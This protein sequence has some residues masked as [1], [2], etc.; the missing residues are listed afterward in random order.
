M[1][2][3]VEVKSRVISSGGI[4]DSDWLED[5]FI[6]QVFSNNS[7]GTLPAAVLNKNRVLGLYY[8]GTSGD[9]DVD[10]ENGGTIDGNNNLI[11]NT[12]TR[13]AAVLSID[14]SGISQSEPWAWKTIWKQ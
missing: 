14:Q 11:L 3:R 2:S 7:N 6:L 10:V 1:S 9:L 13:F 8:H 5:D 12:T 4:D